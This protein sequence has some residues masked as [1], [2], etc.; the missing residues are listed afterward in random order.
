MD[1]NTKTIIIVLVVLV[2]AVLGILAMNAPD[3]RSAGERI[4]DAVENL[5]QGLPAAA[6]QLEDQSAGERMMNDAGEA[7]ENAGEN[8]QQGAE[9]AGQAIEDTTNDAG[10]A[11]EDAFDGEPE[12]Q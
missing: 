3:D 8:I 1:K 10:Q 5:D 2:V 9:D 12:Q 6:E 7:M 11:V 4:G